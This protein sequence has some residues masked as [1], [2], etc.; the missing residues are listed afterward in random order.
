M[1]DPLNSRQKQVLTAIVDHYI[2]KAEPV[3]SKVLSVDPIF[4]A[5]SATIRNTMA[6][7]VE[8]GFVEQPH[9]SAGR[10]P[11]DRGYRTYIDE[12]MHIENLGPEDKNAIE[13]EIAEFQDE[14]EVLAHTARMLER[15]TRQMGLAVSP[16]GEEGLFKNL[17]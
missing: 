9:A 7:L 5:S 14:Q 3:S 17:T 1:G 13:S 16:S 8:M 10:L 6:E 15:L 12:L 2:V 4:Q 11:T